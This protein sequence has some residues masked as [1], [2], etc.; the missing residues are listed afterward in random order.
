MVKGFSGLESA[1]DIHGWR[2]VL[3]DIETDALRN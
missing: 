3:F 2:M 1:A